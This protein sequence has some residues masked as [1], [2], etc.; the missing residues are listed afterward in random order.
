MSSEEGIVDEFVSSV[1]T[2]FYDF[3]LLSKLYHHFLFVSHR[4]LD[5]LKDIVIPIR[6]SPLLVEIHVSVD[7]RLNI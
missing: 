7:L 1:A 5:L 3:L 6:Y 2:V 4:L